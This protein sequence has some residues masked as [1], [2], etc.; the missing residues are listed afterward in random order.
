[1]LA[2][3]E[4]AVFREGIGAGELLHYFL[5]GSETLWGMVDW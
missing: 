3:E 2:L 4:K 1:M 5:E